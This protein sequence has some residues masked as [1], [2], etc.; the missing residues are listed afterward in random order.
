M[1]E[2]SDEEIND[3]ESNLNYI[4]YESSATIKGN[5]TNDIFSRTHKVGMSMNV[6]DHL[7][8]EKQYDFL[9]LQVN[10]KVK[11]HIENSR[12]YKLEK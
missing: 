11:W 7:P 10:N 3:M 8:I 2:F 12:K 6:V 1:I 9:R 5:D 4:S